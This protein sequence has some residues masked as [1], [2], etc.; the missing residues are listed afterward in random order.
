MLDNNRIT[1]FCSVCL[2][3]AQFDVAAS[4]VGRFCATMSR[5]RARRRTIELFLM[6]CIKL[7]LFILV[8]GKS[9]T[10][11]SRHIA[12]CFLSV[13]AKC[14]ET[15]GCRAFAVQQGIANTGSFFVVLFVH[16]CRLCCFYLLLSFFEALNKQTNKQTLLNSDTQQRL[17]I[18]LERDN[19]TSTT[20]KPVTSTEID[21][22]L[23]RVGVFF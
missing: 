22:L 6:V 16:S 5:C 19:A 10:N 8:R 23:R 7:T 13:R 3:I 1:F 14:A 15:C 20:L 21:A 18:D 17:L 4:A 2:I 9:W 12:H 11:V